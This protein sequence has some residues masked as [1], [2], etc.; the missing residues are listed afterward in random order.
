M[1]KRIRVG[2]PLKFES[3]DVLKAKIEEY[4]NSCLPHP[5]QVTTYEF[6]K[7]ITTIERVGRG[8][9][10][11]SKDIEETDYSQKPMEVTTWKISERVKPTITGLAIHL[12]TSRQTLLE[13]QGEVDG[14]EEKSKDFA[15]TIKAAK[16]MIELHW[17]HML[18]GK[19]VTGVIFSLKNNFGWQDR[20]ETEITNPDGSLSPYRALTEEELR[21]LAGK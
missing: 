7:K 2:R 6:H 12:D 8:G 4:F 3:V 5:E 17:E 10:I 15:D 18:E 21:K 14:R 19:N 13:Y 9:K 1:T 11:I 16:D 20:T